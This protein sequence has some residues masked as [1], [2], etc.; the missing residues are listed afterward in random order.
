MYLTLSVVAINLWC[1]YCVRKGVPAAYHTFE[2]WGY[3]VG[4]LIMLFTVCVSYK[5]SHSFKLKEVDRAKEESEESDSPVLEYRFDF[6]WRHLATTATL[7]SMSLG[8]AMYSYLER[9]RT[10]HEAEL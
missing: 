8:A 1:L 9:S 5:E 10:S 4:I 6:G 7:E 2:N 3:S